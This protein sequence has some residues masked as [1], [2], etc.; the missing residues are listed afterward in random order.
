MNKL[1]V[2]LQHQGL[3]KEKKKREMERKEIKFLVGSNL[4]RLSS[5]DGIDLDLYQSVHFLNYI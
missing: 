3:S 4:V 1:W 5:L 2:R